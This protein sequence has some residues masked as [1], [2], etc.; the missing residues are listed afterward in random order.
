[1]AQGVAWCARRLGVP[2]TVVV[3]DHAPATKLAADRAARRAVVQVPFDV[4][5][6]DARGLALSEGVDGLFVHPVRTTAVMAGN[7]T[8]GLEILEDLPDVDAVLVPYGGGG[9]S[10]GIAAAPSRSSRNAR[11]SRSRPRPPRRSPR[12]SPPARRSDR[13][14]AVLR[15]RHRAEGSPPRDV[16]A[17]AG[18]ARRGAR[19]LAR[20]DGRRRPPARRAGARRR[21]GRGSLAV[22]A[23]LAG[24][25]GAGKVVCVVSGGNIDAARLAAVLSGQTPP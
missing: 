10:C 1:M 4:L 24:R 14:P 17:V 13:L 12:R 23:A 19:R 25:A 2:A 21:R 15:R 5:V 20:G 7:G 3:P 11:L 9:L 18:A 6:A 8:I 22:A 16:A